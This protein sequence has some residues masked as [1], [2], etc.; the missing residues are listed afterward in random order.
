MSAVAAGPPATIAAR[1]RRTSHTYYGA[2]HALK[3]VSLVV[4]EGEIVT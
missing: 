3:G 4:G 2:I 1:P